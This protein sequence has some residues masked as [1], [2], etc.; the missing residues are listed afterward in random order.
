MS[1]LLGHKP[2]LWMEKG[3]WAMT[4]HAGPVRI[5][6]CSN[7][8]QRLNVPSE[9]RRN[10]IEDFW[11]LTDHCERLHTNDLYS[12]TGF[13]DGEIL[14]GPH[15]ENWRVPLGVFQA[16]GMALRGESPLRLEPL[17]HSNLRKLK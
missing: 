12:V 14:R 7:R 16:D 5:S 10:S 11:S 3:D 6:G 9:A 2:F 17:D 13:R 4:H 15:A 8:D 1:P